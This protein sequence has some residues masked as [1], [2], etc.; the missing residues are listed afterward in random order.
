MSRECRRC[1]ECCRRGGPV[2]HSEDRGLFAG[3]IISITDV[4]RVRKDEPAFDPMQ[5][6]VVR[7]AAEMLKIGGSGRSWSCRFF[8]PDPPACTVHADRPLEC[9]LFF[10]RAPEDLA[11]VAGSDLLALPAV[12]DLD[13]ALSGLAGEFDRTFPFSAFNVLLRKAVHDRGALA[14]L[15]DLVNR[16]L[17][18]RMKTCAARCLSPSLEAAI[19]GRP[20]FLSAAASGFEV[21]ER[22]GG[23]A[24]RPPV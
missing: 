11:A 15:S 12:P 6:R 21:R 14:E 5:G 23:L 19:L 24:L 2:L 3:K 1:G 4:V 17:R 16:E 9:R 10:C 18:F 22:E 7:A 8:S 13:P 20:F